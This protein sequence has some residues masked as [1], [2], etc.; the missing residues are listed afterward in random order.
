MADEA[1]R[2]VEPHDAILRVDALR[3]MGAAWAGDADAASAECSPL[4]A[5]DAELAQ[6]PPTQI[7]VGQHDMF[8][9]DNRSFARRLNSAGGEVQLYEYAR[10]PHVFM[11]ITNTREARDCLRL[12][13]NFLE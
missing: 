10:A 6:L 9:I 8:V 1:A 5:S 2:N 4:Y 7:F 3:A 11:A 12:V 13:A